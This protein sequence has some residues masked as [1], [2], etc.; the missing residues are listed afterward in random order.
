MKRDLFRATAAV[1]ALVLLVSSAWGDSPRQ[2]SGAGLGDVSHAEVAAA[3]P[4]DILRVWPQEGGSSA[5]GRAFRILYRSTS[6]AGEPLAVSGAIFVPD[7]LAPPE[8]RKVVAWAH[9]TTGVVGK[10]APT[11]LPDLSGTIPGLDDML[12][13]GFVVVATDY[14]GL[15][16]PGQHP[17]LIGESEARSVL[18]SVRAARRFPGA[19]AGDIFTVWGHSQGGHAALFTGQLAAS[20]A[21]ELKLAGVAAAAPATELAQL[22]DADINTNAGRTLSAMALY[23]WAK[24]FD[25]P[26]ASI[27]D[28]SAK[29]SFESV[30]HDCIESLSEMLKIEQDTEGL[31]QRFLKGNPTKLAPWK[32]IMARNSPGAAPVGAPVFIAQGTADDIVRPHITKRYAEALCHAGTRVH[33]LA[34]DGVSH[35][36]AGMDSADA[37]V[38]WMADR[39]AGSPAPSDCRR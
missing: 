28:A 35:T 9:P 20:Y 25:A 10:C 19:K 36:F 3:K 37:A 7:D 27:L 26:L 1:T 22:F 23:S 5:G 18:D 6:I 11:L 24:V 13:R 30:A 29:G 31:Y 8:G 14:V 16:T 4:G 32:D 12:S 34:L 15:G 17:Y 38:A 21:P 39:L 2:A 33:M